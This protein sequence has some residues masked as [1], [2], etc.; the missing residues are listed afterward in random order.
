MLMRVFNCSAASDSA[1][2]WLLSTF[3][4][5]PPR[6]QRSAWMMASV[7]AALRRSE[8]RVRQVADR[9][10]WAARRPTRAVR[11][12][13][14]DCAHRGSGRSLNDLRFDSAALVPHTALHLSNAGNKR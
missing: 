14:R 1:L 11:E 5:S 13:R 9:C 3:K 8:Q 7:Q 10:A 4:S 12:V 2:N 6:P